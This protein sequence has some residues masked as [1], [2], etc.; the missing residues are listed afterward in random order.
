MGLAVPRPAMRARE[1]RMIRARL[2]YYDKRMAEL[3]AHGML[4][5]EA[6]TQAFKEARKLIFNR[7]GETV[8]TWAT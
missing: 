6:S 4:H 5:N 3:H 2:K 7:S 1:E 8:T